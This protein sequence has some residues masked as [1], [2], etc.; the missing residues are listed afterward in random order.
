MG[1]MP[2]NLRLRSFHW[3]PA[4]NP[5]ALPNGMLPTLGSTHTVTLLRTEFALHRTSLAG[6]LFEAIA[7]LTFSN[8][9]RPVCLFS[10]AVWMNGPQSYL[11]IIEFLQGNPSPMSGRPPTAEFRF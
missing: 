2:S 5:S 6:N 11:R 4:I 8:R 10:Q 9:R 1:F 7:V 3:A